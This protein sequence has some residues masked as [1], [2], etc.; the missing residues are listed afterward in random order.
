[1]VHNGIASTCL[2]LPHFVQDPD[3]RITAAEFLTRVSNLMNSDA[4]RAMDEARKA[5]IYT[6][7][8]GCGCCVM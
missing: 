1:M 6:G 7:D 4:A 8:C 5:S 2:K 3:Q